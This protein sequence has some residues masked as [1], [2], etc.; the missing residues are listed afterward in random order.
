LLPNGLRLQ[1]LKPNGK[2]STAPSDKQ[3]LQASVKRY[4]CIFGFSKS[5]SSEPESIESAD[6]R[7]VCIN[8]LE[9]QTRR[10]KQPFS[11]TTKLH[12]EAVLEL[13]GTAGGNR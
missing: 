2:P 11:P 5:R 7:H 6:D 12:V 10:Q 4:V 3:A 1:P 8:Q 13:S 9:E